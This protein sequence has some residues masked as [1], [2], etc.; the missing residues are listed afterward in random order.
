M[1]ASI[2]PRRSA[3]KADIDRAIKAVTSAGLKVAS[4][5][6]GPDGTVEVLTGGF[7]GDV[8][9]DE[10]ETWRAQRDARKARA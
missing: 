6:V 3:R 9:A 4:V 8:V 2:V 10:L 7:K 1:S 5:K